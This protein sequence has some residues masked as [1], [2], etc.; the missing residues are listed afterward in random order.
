MRSTNSTDWLRFVALD[1]SVEATT[2]RE[3]TLHCLIDIVDYKVQVNRGPVTLEVTS[4]VA[5]RPGLEGA[6]PEGLS[7]ELQPRPV[8][9]AVHQG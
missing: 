6:E 1:L 7:V 4:D 9:V 5:M 2:R 3:R 8:G